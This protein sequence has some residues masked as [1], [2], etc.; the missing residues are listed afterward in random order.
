MYHNKENN[1]KVLT[2]IFIT[3]SNVSLSFLLFSLKTFSLR[4][5]GCTTLYSINKIKSYKI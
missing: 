4:G 2:Y 1:Y 3:R 5:D